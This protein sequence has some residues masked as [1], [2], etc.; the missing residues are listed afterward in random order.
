MYNW[1]YHNYSKQSGSHVSISMYTTES[2]QARSKLKKPFLKSV[3]YT[4]NKGIIHAAY[5]ETGLQLGAADATYCTFMSTSV[6]LH[7][8]R[9]AS[10]RQW[11][12]IE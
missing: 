3:E 5:S 11:A 4:T 6:C 10:A 12:F 1:I 7:Q 9:G 2:L 8:T